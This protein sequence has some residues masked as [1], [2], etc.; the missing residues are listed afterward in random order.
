MARTKPR[1]TKDEVNKLR[2][3][4]IEDKPI[5]FIVNDLKKSEYSFWRKTL[6]ILENER[7]YL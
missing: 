6:L 2:E 3:L 1:W 7:T 4:I 5:A